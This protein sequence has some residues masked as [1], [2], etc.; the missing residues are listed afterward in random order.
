MT[1]TITDAP[2]HQPLHDLI[3]SHAPLPSKADLDGRVRQLIP[4]AVQSQL[5]LLMFDGDDVQMPVMM[6]IGELLL[7]GD[8]ALVDLLLA[9]RREFGPES[10]VFM[11]ERVGPRSLG[12]DDRAGLARLLTAGDGCGLLV[13][14]AY[15]CHDDGVSGYDSGDLDELSRR[16]HQA[17]S[18]SSFDM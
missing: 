10:F 4:C 8:A 13:R 11:L 17:V 12:D 6:P 15:L 5:W 18:A 1:S 9:L 7:E 16:R 14:A 3:D 2:F